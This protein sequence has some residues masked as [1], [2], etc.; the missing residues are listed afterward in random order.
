MKS[1]K[2]YINENHGASGSRYSRLFQQ[3][4]DMDQ[5]MRNE[6]S[7]SYAE[8]YGKEF[9]QE[10]WD[11]NL[12]QFIEKHQTT[13]DDVF[14]DA[15]RLN[16]LKE[17]LPKFDYNEFSEKDWEHFWILA[18][19]ADDDE[20]LQKQALSIL[21]KYKKKQYYFN[22]LWRIANNKGIMDKL[23]QKAGIKKP[24]TMDLDQLS[25]TMKKIAEKFNVNVNT[26]YKDIASKVLS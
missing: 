11:A 24:T 14:G 10:L 26:L 23:Y 18:Q 19:H 21:G 2:Q 7:N 17:L 16:Q 5:S 4:S 13:L 3:W 15:K 1:F 6:L 20:Y 8:K 9:N 22:L 25:S 12:K